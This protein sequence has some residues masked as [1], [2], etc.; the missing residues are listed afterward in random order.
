MVS[1]KLYGDWLGEPV[2]GKRDMRV[3]AIFSTFVGYFVIL[4]RGT[5]LYNTLEKHCRPS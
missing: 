2:D 4:M 3:L 1:G 5:N